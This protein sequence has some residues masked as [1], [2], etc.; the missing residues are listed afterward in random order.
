MPDVKIYIRRSN[1]AAWEALENKSDWV[2]TLL[3]EQINERPTLEE[4]EPALSDE[5]LREVFR[6]KKEKEAIA[7]VELQERIEAQIKQRGWTYMGI[8]EGTDVHLAKDQL[9]TVIKF[10]FINGEIVVE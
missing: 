7:A 2:N 8:S 3:A 9:G 4:N 6:L 1:M 5:E 10:K